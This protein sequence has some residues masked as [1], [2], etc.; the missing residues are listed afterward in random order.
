[1][2]TLIFAPNPSLYFS[3]QK[4]FPTFHPKVTSKKQVNIPLTTLKIQASAKGFSKKRPTSSSTNKTKDDAITMKKNPKNNNDDDDVITKVV[5]YRIVGRI[6]FSV[7]V[8]MGVGLGFL[9]LYGELEDREILNAPIWIP[10]VTTL[11]TFGASALGIAYGALS[12][13][14]D[15]DREGS[16]LGFQE[17]EKNWVEMWQQENLTKLFQE[18]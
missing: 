12:T 4:I 5:M 1:M 15:E 18:F 2:K 10:F 13:S 9:Q 8:P 7:L 6:S 11:I 16:L 3:K 17:L 14:L